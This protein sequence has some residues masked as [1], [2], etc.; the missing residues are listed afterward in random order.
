[1]CIYKKNK[2]CYFGFLKLIQDRYYFQIDF[3]SCSSRY[4]FNLKYYICN[5]YVLMRLCLGGLTLKS[6]FNH[7]LG[8]LRGE[9]RRNFYSLFYY[10]TL[11][12]NNFHCPRLF[13]IALKVWVVDIRIKQHFCQTILG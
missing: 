7:T 1:M 13:G 6:I 3:M 10:I 2:L 9:F 12:Y 11:L 5:L 4:H 8:C